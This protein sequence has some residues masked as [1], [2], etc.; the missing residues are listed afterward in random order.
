MS[1]FMQVYSNDLLSWRIATTLLVPNDGLT[2]EQSLWMTGYH[3]AGG[4]CHGHCCAS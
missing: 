2:W 1:A 3:Y 4:L